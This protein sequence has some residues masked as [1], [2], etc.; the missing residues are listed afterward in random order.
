M[1]EDIF[2]HLFIIE[3]IIELLNINSADL[4]RKSS[5][6]TTPTKI[7]LLPPNNGSNALCKDK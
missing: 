7:I 2:E 5:T 1:I 6:H 4:K 3:Q